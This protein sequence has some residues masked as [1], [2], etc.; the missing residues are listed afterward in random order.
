MR[1]G[2]PYGGQDPS[3]RAMRSEDARSLERRSMFDTIERLQAELAD[4]Q[5]AHEIAL[6]LVGLPPSQQR[7]KGQ[8]YRSYLVENKF[9]NVREMVQRLLA[10]P[11][12]A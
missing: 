5:K 10:I 1:S 11:E 7:H 12:G 6:E 3:S 4:Y 9:P 8:Y 2:G